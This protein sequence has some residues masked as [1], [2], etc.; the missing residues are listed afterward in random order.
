MG[1]E[2]ETMCDHKIT[3]G[4][5]LLSRKI[6]ESGI[7]SKPPLY[8][9]VWIFI[10][11]KAQHKDYK[12]LKRGQL[13][14]SIPEIMEKCSW[15]IGYRKVTPSKDQI[16]QVL[17]WL[18]EPN[19]N[20]YRKPYATSYEGGTGATMITTTRATQGLLVN[21]DN[22]EIYQNLKNY[23]GND[24]PD[25]ENLA[26]A[27]R[28]QRTPDNINKNDKECSNNVNKNI[29][30]VEPTPYKQILDLFNSTCIM[31]PKIKSIEDN[32]KK[33][34][35]TR[36]KGNPNIGYFQNLFN[37]VNKSDFLSG[38]EGSWKGCCFDWIFKPANLQKIIEG[39]YNNKNNN[40]NQTSNSNN[41][42]FTGLEE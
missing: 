17:E 18:R 42:D 30:S 20:N 5:I 35:N 10:L 38:R 4:C 29:L 34:I 8:L 24:E 40:V 31:L 3:G 13:R 6:I 14:I 26:G 39:N 15:H 7:W 23:E 28:E 1:L 33:I 2:G 36:W 32:R 9:K 21:I 22:Y 19:G 37:V 41:F 27:T 16:F 25:N 11:S 12:L